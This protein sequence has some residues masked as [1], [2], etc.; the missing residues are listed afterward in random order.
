M[1][2]SVLSKV[3]FYINNGWP[4]TCSQVMTEAKLFFKICN[5]LTV[6]NRIEASPVVIP[7]SMQQSIKSKL[8]T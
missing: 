6:I 5:E 3:Y 8:Y 7:K 4:T 2:D 1:K